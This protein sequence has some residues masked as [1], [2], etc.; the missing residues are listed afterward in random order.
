M[1]QR[2]SHRLALTGLLAVLAVAGFGSGLSRGDDPKKDDPKKDE[3][4]YETKGGKAAASARSIDFSEALGLGLASL[5]SMGTRIVRALEAR[6]PVALTSL[7]KELAAAESVAEK[8]AAITSDKLLQEAIE[9]AKRRN[10]PAELKTVAKLLG[11]AKEAKELLAQAEKVEKEIALR[12]K[13]PGKIAGKGITGTVTVQNF[14]PYYISIYVNDLSVGTV[15]P[16]SSA[17]GYVGDSP[18]KNTKLYGYAPGTTLTWGPTY[19][20]GNVGNYTWSLTPP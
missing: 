3:K 14:T 10:H 5:E 20:T 13:D 9:M 6:D 7:A 16:Y 1:L 15:N 19:V 12:A 4:K 2:W 18:F 11:D 8:K 17:I